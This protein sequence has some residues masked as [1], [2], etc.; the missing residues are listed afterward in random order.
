MRV[1]SRRPFASVIGSALVLLFGFGIAYTQGPSPS[2]TPLAE[3]EFGSSKFEFRS[4]EVENGVVKFDGWFVVGANQP[5]DQSYTIVAGIMD[6]DDVVYGELNLGSVDV[7]AWP[8][9]PT[10]FEF[11]GE[12]P[13]PPG[14][15]GVV[16]AS[17]EKNDLLAEGE[18]PNETNSTITCRDSHI[19]I[20]P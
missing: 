17:Y 6:S 4:V 13:M 2:N 9:H 12:Q 11:H 10:Y 1:L 14:K 7:A 15:Y 18:L 3:G 16:M 19:F 8:L 5:Y 20:L